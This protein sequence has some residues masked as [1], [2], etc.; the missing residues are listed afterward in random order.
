MKWTEEQPTTPGWYWI[1]CSKWPGVAVCQVYFNEGFLCFAFSRI[2]NEKER[3]LSGCGGLDT[4][5]SSERN[6]VYEWLGPL[7][8]PA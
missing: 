4:P 5:L 1:R 7:E 8:I 2:G 3:G 6:G